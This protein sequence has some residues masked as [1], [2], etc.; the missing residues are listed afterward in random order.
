M[1]RSMAAPAVTILNV[2]PGGYSPMVAVGPSTSA[3]AFC[4]TARISPVDGLIDDEHRL[5]ALSVDG[6]LRGVLHGPVQRDRHRRRRRRRDL[7]EHVDVDAVLVDAD[8]LPA[9]LAVELLR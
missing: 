7:V 1:L 9:G 8:D 3:A 4:A 2:D 5:E 6:M